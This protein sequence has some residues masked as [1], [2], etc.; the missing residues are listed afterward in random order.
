MKHD[1][2]TLNPPGE[3]A[4][5]D[6]C[7]HPGGRPAKQERSNWGERLA[8]ARARSGLSQKDLADKMGVTQQAIAAWERKI[9]AVRSDTLM[10]LASI[11]GISSDELLGIKPGRKNSPSGKLHRVFEEVSKLPRRQQQK[12]VEFVEAFVE[13]KS[14]SR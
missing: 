12:V 11:L 4:V 7:M 3:K 1:V 13:K 2:V 14:A 8:Q 6:V 5:Y 10:R 9:T